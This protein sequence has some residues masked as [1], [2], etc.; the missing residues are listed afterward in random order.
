M[1]RK[2]PLLPAEA[3]RRVIRTA[4]LDGGGILAVA[5]FFALASASIHDVNGAAVGLLVAAGGT[6]EFHGAGLLTVGVRT[7]A[8]WLVSSQ[9]FLLAVILAYVAWRLH[10][11]DISPMRPLL[12][13]EQRSVIAG[14]GFGVDEFL[15]L[16]YRTTYGVFGVA[17]LAYQGGLALYYWRRRAAIKAALV[18][19]D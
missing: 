4:R 8:R 1:A 12:T 9:V 16:I 13:E 19:E 3:L 6:M 17:S 5:G 11:M 14:A 15:R 2:P 18:Y 10:G 7:G